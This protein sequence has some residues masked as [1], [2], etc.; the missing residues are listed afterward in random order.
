[1]PTEKKK[2]QPAHKWRVQD[3]DI[4]E[5]E[6]KRILGEAGRKGVATQRRRKALREVARAILDAELT[7][8][9]EIRDELARRG[10]ETTEGTA[11]LYAQLRRARNGDVEAARFLRDT[12]GQKPVE[13]VAV[14]NMDD[15]P[16]ETI[17]LS[18]LTD[19]QLKSLI[20]DM[21]EQQTTEEAGG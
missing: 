2:K 5:E 19:A 12:S 17:E 8:E 3:M 11:V 13:N 1:M 21:Q 4:P 14:G 20:L 16:F 9:D 10:F 7:T 18:G 6:K 15:R